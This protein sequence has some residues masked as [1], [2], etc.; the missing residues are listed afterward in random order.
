M[1]L[2]INIDHIAT[3]RNQRD[4]AYPDLVEAARICMAAGADGIT[5]HLREDRRHIRD[6]DVWAL[7][8]EHKGLLNL[9]MAATDQMAAIAAEVKPD[10]VTL[11]PEKREERTT[12]GGLDV[13][14]TR[15]AV[16]KVAEVCRQ[17]GIKLS[18]FIEADEAQ[19]RASK[20]VGAAQVEFHTGHYCEAPLAERKELL[21]ELEKAA[22]LAESLGLEVAAGH[23]LNVENVGPIAAISGI[24]E[25]NIGHSVICAAVMVGLGPAVQEL[26]GSVEMGRPT[27]V[28]AE[29]MHLIAESAALRGQ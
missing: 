25:L 12:E 22:E 17:A 9:E 10:V 20:E 28:P 23:G 5:V 4:T 26:R 29:P 14:K 2:H 1:R 8:A 27:S 21:L 6:A 15:A 24:R 3:L 19:V 13:I 18:L 7:R 11:V 16:L